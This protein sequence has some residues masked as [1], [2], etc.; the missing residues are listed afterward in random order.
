MKIRNG[1]VSNSSSSSFCII[2]M[3]FDDDD[4]KKY[5]AKIENIT[6]EDEI[7]DIDITDYFYDKNRDIDIETGIG[8][9]YEQHILGKYYSDMKD[10]ETK[11]HFEARVKKLLED[12]L[13]NIGEEIRVALHYDGGYEG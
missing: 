9:Y 6:D 5:I 2:G 7:E 1:F 3:A 10:D 11:A 8:E 13:P 12:T 4:L